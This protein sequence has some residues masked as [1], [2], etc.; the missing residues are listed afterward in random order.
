[1]VGSLLHCYLFPDPKNR[2]TYLIGREK[3]QQEALHSNAMTRIPYLK[4]IYPHWRN[5]SKPDFITLIH[6]W[7]ISCRIRLQLLQ[8]STSI[9]LNVTVYPQPI[10]TSL[11]Q[12]RHIITSGAYDDTIAGVAT[13]QISVAA[14]KY[15]VVPSTYNPGSEVGFK[16]IVY[17]SIAGLMVT[18]R[19]NQ[20]N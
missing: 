19:V 12:Q 5:W 17:S 9:A 10:T 15:Y 1:M 16:L 18:Q 14:G 8:P 3:Q 11:N 13:P 7:N 6:S 2:P 4:L 20:V